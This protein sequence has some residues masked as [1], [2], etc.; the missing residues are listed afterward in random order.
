MNKEQAKKRIEELTKEINEH[1]YYYYVLD[2][3]LISD[4]KFDLLLKELDQLENDFP[5]FL[6]TNSPT[7]RV[8]GE[9]TKE[10]AKIKH[11]YPMLSLGNTYSMQEVID[12]DERVRKV[13]GNDFEYVCEFKYDGLSIG[14]TYIDGN[15]KYAVTRGDGEQGDD[16]TANVRTIKSIPLTLHGSDFPDEFEIRGEIIMPHK[17]FQRLNDEREEIGETPFANPRNAASGS[18]KMQDTKEVSKR[19]L[20]CFLYYLLGENLPFNTHFENLKTA[21]NWGFKISDY[22]K[23]CPNIKGVLDYIKE[24]DIKR[25]TL[26]FDI[27]GVVIKINSFNQQEMLGYTAKNPKWAIAYKFKAE[28]VS[29][30]LL[31]IDFQVGRTGAITPVA[32]LEPV[33]LAGTIVKRAT[34]HNADQIEKL[35]LHNGD[36]VF[37]EK[38]GEIIPKIISVDES[39]RDLINSKKVEFIT[40]CPECGT[41]LFRKEGEAIHY[42]P[43]DTGCAPQIKGKLEHFISRKAMNIDSLGEG[44]IE[45]L[46]ENDLVKNPLDLYKLTYEK[47]FNLGKSYTSEE[48]GKTRTVKFKEKAAENILKGIEESKK[49]PFERVLYAL[50][51]RY[52]G[53]TVAKKLAFH[54]RNIDALK[55]AAFDELI[56]VEE[57]GNRIA[58]SI[59]TF[60]SKQINLDLINN[61]KIVGLQFEINENLTLFVSDKLKNKSFV[62]SGV[63]T[64]YSR[65]KIKKIIEEN[66]G[67]IISTVSSKTNFLLAGESMGP[68]KKKKAE[69]LNVPIISEEEFLKMLE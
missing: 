25:K 66:G 14:L 18:L 23:K 17:S 6:N 54:F 62:V 20:D 37:V 61:L 65:E 51:I 11:K 35:N 67:K 19:G 42:C 69:A 41:L 48:S 55:N 64:K 52:V 44:K 15:L 43:N 5:E 9:V 33:Q 34:L 31:S 36:F 45:L 63:F 50:G 59:I 58:E 32:N 12:F 56:N 40:N 22:N 30:K 13:I 28:Q 7:Q 26:D 47:L 49:M 4:F 60:F 2:S 1:N 53:E 38:G 68:E 29:T 24:I 10:F 3:P 39:K 21:R 16:V 27:D 46:F 57:I 8:G